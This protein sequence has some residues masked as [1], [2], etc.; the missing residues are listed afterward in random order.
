MVGHEILSEENNTDWLNTLLHSSFRKCKDHRDLR[1]SDKNV[2]CIDCTLRLCKHCKEAHS[3]HRR[4]QIYRYVYQD[5]VR[6]SD[7]QKHFD[8]SKIQTYIS[9]NERII[10]LHPRPALDDTNPTRRSKCG[11]HCPK[12]QFKVTKLSSRLK[13]GGACEECG[14]NLQDER[15]RFCSIACKI[16]VVSM[17][18]LHG[19]Q[20][21]ERTSEGPVNQCA[22]LITTQKPE[23]LGPSL[24]DDNQNSETESSISVAESDDR[25]ELMNFRKRPRKG[26]PQRSPFL[27]MS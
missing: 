22:K 26:L 17:E 10:H 4:L 13:S 16:S 5:V 8:C 19:N 27:C 2:F 11:D 1:Y 18:E 6:L 25:F 9:N 23:V 15:N 7:L 20:N 3:L 12:P 21:S 24:N 14:R